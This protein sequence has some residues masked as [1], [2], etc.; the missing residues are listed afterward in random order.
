MKCVPTFLNVKLKAGNS[1]SCHYFPELLRKT[2]KN[3]ELIPFELHNVHFLS[4]PYKCKLLCNRHTAY[5]ELL[6]FFMYS[7]YQLLLF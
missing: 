6:I 5:S 2:I 3:L 4:G 1:N 7:L